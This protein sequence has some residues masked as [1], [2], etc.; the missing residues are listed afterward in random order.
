MT[1]LCAVSRCRPPGRHRDGCTDHHCRG[2]IPAPAAD[3][4]R[5]C[6]FHT[7][8][9]GADAREA[10]RLHS[11]LEH[12]LVGGDGHGERTTG[13]TVDHSLPINEAVVDARATIAHVLANWCKLIA[14]ERG[15][16]LPW[17]WELQPLP[18]GVYGPPR[19]VHRITE[20]PPSLGRYIDTHSTWLAAH[21]LAADASDE[22]DDLVR[23]ARRLAYPSG[24]RIVEI[25]PCPMDDC[26]G[27]VRAVLR[28]ADALLPSMLA[29]TDDTTHT[30][31]A[32]SWR[33]FA[34]V[35]HGRT[36]R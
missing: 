25:S 5:L 32:T 28:P 36:T 35:V 19:L 29:C 2:C 11:E 23:Q 34:R 10:A 20:A 4:L 13:G 17:V 7:N 8:R 27:T 6:R 3:G 31:P 14:D 24:S 16:S 12:C 26:A 15:L 1:V 21:E 9:L 22:L 18:E 33:A 30:W